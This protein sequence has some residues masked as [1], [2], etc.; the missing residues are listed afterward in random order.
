MIIEH[1]PEGLIRHI[2]FDPVPPDLFETMDAN[3][4]EYRNFPPIMTEN[5]TQN[6]ECD[7]MLDYINDGQITRRPAINVPATAQLTVGETF[8]LTG[9][10]DPIEV[11]LD[12]EVSELTGGTLELSADMPAEYTLVLEKWP[13]QTAI[14]KVTVNA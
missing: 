3:G 2:V 12:G 8:T 1:T 10:P 4:I 6:V 5:G 9:L 14:L 13:Y 7:P 11:I